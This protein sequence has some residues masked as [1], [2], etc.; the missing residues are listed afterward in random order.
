MG[1]IRALSAPMVRG[2]LIATTRRLPRPAEGGGLRA[3]SVA[4]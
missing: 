2:P 1:R 4:E 3:V